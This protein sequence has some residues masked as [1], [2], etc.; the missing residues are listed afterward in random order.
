MSRNGIFLFIALAIALSA[1]SNKSTPSNANSGPSQQPKENVQINPDQK[2][3]DGFTPLMNAIKNNNHDGAI[4]AI[5]NGANVDAASPSGITAL[6][7]A[8]GMGDKDLVR[9][10]IDKGANVNHRADGGFTPLMQAALI[11]Q[12]EI[13]RML[14]DAGADPTVKDTAGKSASDYATEKNH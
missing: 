8:S 3:V 14:L 7:L 13:A 1:C 12:T 5:Q 2:D 9:T 10:L 11:G 4:Q 6:F